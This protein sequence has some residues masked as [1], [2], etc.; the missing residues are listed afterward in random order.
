[1]EFKL[2]CMPQDD[3]IGSSP[4]K[5]TGSIFAQ[6]SSTRKLTAQLNSNS[7]LQLD[8]PDRAIWANIIWQEKNSI[9]V[10]KE[11][12][13]AVSQEE[14]S[15]SSQPRKKVGFRHRWP[16]K[17]GKHQLCLFWFSI[18]ILKIWQDYGLQILFGPLKK[19]NL[20][21]NRL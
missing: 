4:Y 11:N 2:C 20:L 12:S 14:I 19:Y 5:C 1:M 21:P 3:S 6:L 9:A 18:I 16:I 15:S 7:T 13:P 10:I 8:E 17:T